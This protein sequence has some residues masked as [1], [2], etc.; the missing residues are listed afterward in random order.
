MH[1]Y[2]KIVK[3]KANRGNFILYKCDNKEREK[4]YE[5][6]NFPNLRDLKQINNTKLL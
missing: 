1:Q 4:I 6:Y 5:D 3:R 2:N